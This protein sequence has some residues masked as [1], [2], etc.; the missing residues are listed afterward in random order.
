M[1]RIGEKLR[2]L[3][4]R[5][6]LTT[7]QLGQMLGIDSTYVVRIENGQRRP[8]IDIVANIARHFKISAD[9]LIMDELELD[10]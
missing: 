2:M 8:S 3:R 9:R 4:Q 10:D 7:R 5:E 1:S 6:G